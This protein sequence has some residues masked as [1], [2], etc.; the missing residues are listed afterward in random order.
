M[1]VRGG[2]ILK[3]LLSESNTS[4]SDFA[5]RAGVERVTLHRVLH[6]ARWE[7]IPIDL[8]MRCC[9]AVGR[10][11]SPEDFESIT[12]LPPGEEGEEGPRRRARKEAA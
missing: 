2:R 11:L 6:G 5:K 1:I 12:A 4:L 8:V 9:R 10:G 3:R 7:N